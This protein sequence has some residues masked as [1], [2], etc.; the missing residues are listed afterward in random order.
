MEIKFEKASVGDAQSIFELFCELVE[1]YEDLTINNYEKIKKWEKFKLS[2]SLSEYYSIF[3]DDEKV[4]YVH[5]FQNES[6]MEID[7]FYVLNEFRN[8]GVGTETLRKLKSSTDMP[9]SLFV[10]KSNLGAIKFYERE[11]FK[12]K[13]DIDERRMVLEYKR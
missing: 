11:G 9:I 4:G 13:E 1:K 7:D 6:S 2:N 3:C 10:F 12:F 8:R 5:F